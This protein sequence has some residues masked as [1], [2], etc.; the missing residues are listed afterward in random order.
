MTGA[1]YA[2]TLTERTA[3]NARMRVVFR[4]SIG[5]ILSEFELPVYQLFPPDPSG[6]RSTPRLERESHLRK[7]ALCSEG[8]ARRFSRVRA[9]AVSEGRPFRLESSRTLPRYLSTLHGPEASRLLTCTTPRPERPI[10]P[11]RTR[12][13]AREINYC[14]ESFL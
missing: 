4:L 3:S 6:P 12:T 2:K 9:P 13:E 11:R 10:S 5:L 14:N 1:A 8:S 7:L